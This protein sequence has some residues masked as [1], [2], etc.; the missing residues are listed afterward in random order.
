MTCSGSRVGCVSA[1]RL[2][3]LAPDQFGK[4]NEMMVSFAR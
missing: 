1:L 2:V 3:Q 4:A